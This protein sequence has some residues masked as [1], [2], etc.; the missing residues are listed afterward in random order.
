MSSAGF[1]VIV[2]NPPYGA[3]LDEQDFAFYSKNYKS[4]EYRIDTYTL[5]FEKAIDL[6]RTS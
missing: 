1:D 2:G 4:S 5:F 3:K 6:V